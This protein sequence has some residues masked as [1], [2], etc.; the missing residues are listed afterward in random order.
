MTNY[1]EISGTAF[2][3]LAMLYMGNRRMNLINQYQSVVFMGFIDVGLVEALMQ[4]IQDPN[5]N[6]ATRASILV[7]ELREISSELMP[8]SA[9]VKINV[10]SRGC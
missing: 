4:V 6:I 10:I 1:K 3:Q 8:Q 2:N 7:R 9:N 5:K